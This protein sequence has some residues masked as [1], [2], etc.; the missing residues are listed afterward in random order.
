MAPVTA[1]GH[2][3]STMCAM[4]LRTDAVLRTAAT[5][6][7]CTGMLT[8][9]TEM[10]HSVL[11]T[12][13]VKHKTYPGE[14]GRKDINEPPTRIGP[15]LA[16]ITFVAPTDVRIDLYCLTGAKHAADSSFVS[17]QEARHLYD[18]VCR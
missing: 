13:I 17:T 16:T 15:L 14:P 6:S 8:H 7:S 10:I 9:V 3:S 4:C 2:D 5:H 1:P 11:P 18:L 12:A